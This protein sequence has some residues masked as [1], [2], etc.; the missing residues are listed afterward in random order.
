MRKLR[1]LTLLLTFLSIALSAFPMNNLNV[2][3]G[4]GGGSVYAVFKDRYGLM[5]FGTSNGLNCYDGL[6]MKTYNASEMRRRNEMYDITQTDD[7]MMYAATAGGVFTLDLNGRGRMK[8]VKESPEERINVVK[9]SGRELYVGCGS[10]LYIMED[11]EVKSHIMLQNDRM[12]K[13]NTVN[14]IV[15]TRDVLWLLGNRDIWRYDRNTRRVQPMNLPK[16]VKVNGRLRVLAL[17]G[18]RLFAGSYNDGVVWLDVKGNGGGRYVSVGS[19]VITDMQVADK[20]LYVATDGAGVSVVSLATDEII[21]T[22]NTQNGLADNSVYSFL[23]TDS[24]INWFGYFRRGVSHDYFSSPLFHYFE[25]NGF[26]TYGLNV[27]SFC[28]DG[29][30]KVIGTREGLYYYDGQTSRYYSPGELGGGGIVTSVVKYAGMYYIATFDNGVCRLDPATGR[31]E[32]FGNNILLETASFGRLAV[33]PTDEL[34]MASNAGVFVYNAA[35]NEVHSF[36]SRNSQL[37]DSYANSL[38]FDRHGRCWI[39]THEGM[40]VYNPIDGMLRTQGFPENFKSNVPEPNFILALDNNILSYSAE[41]LYRISEELDDFGTIESNPVISNTLI[42]FVVCDTKAKQYWVGTEH[43]LFCFD[44]D[45]KNYR[46]YGYSFG[47][48]SSEFSTNAGYIDAET[49]YVDRVDERTRV[50]GPERA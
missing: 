15:V 10:G 35:K 47:M 32:R 6:T 50:C 38:L 25:G 8:R 22:Y 2:Y 18:K 40:C 23:R 13:E 24:G 26:S 33:S 43:G 9:T 20:Q 31:I 44:K 14:D 11:G 46:T 30:R 39:G 19:N 12:S 5:W 42:N 34:W 29:E 45:F 1:I 37:F 48:Q 21:N 3:N 49:P 7:G 27:R 28:I 16:K 36:D 17:A 4:L 41:G